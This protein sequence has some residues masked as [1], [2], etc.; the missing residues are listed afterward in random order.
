MHRG[1]ICFHLNR[2]TD[3]HLK[4]KAAAAATIT[5]LPDHCFCQKLSN[6]S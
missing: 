6:N 3:E 2:V 4:Q 1:Y 5:S